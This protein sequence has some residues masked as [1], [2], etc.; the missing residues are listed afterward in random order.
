[1]NI[2]DAW[3]IWAQTQE[4][5]Q[6]AQPQAEPPKTYT[7]ARQLYDAAQWEAEYGDEDKKQWFFALC[8]RLLEKLT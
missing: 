8:E 4:G 7:R 6:A 2:Q 3:K 1:M 5:T